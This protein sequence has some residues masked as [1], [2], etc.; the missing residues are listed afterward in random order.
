RGRGTQI[1]ISMAAKYLAKRI[2][3]NIH[4]TAPSSANRGIITITALDTSHPT[5][6]T[7]ERS[8]REREWG[9]LQM[10]RLRM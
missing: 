2:T 9:Q 7:E 4:R 8:Q 1:L 5:E 6:R 3:I 10:A